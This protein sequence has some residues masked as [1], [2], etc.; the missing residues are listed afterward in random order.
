MLESP[1]Q[2]ITIAEVEVAL[3]VDVLEHFQIPLFER[4]LIFARRKRLIH[5]D[6]DC[7]FYRVNWVV[8]D[9][10]AFRSLGY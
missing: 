9:K 8:P 3:Q 2:I 5:F 4:V 7:I 6:H 10:S 1:S